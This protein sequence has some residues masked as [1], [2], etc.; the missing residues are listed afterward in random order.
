VQNHPVTGAWMDV[1]ERTRDDLVRGKGPER[2]TVTP[3]TWEMVRDGN[4]CVT[5]TSIRYIVRSLP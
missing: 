4:S 1:Q 2:P 5:S 3:G